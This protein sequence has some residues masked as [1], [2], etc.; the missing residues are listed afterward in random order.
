MAT[1]SL[2][3]A[4]VS[5]LRSLKDTYK[6]RTLRTVHAVHSVICTVDTVYSVH[7]V[8]VVLVSAVE[9]AVYVKML[10][11]HYSSHPHYGLIITVALL[12]W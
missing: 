3:I 12:L 11:Q 7:C 4:R 6:G 9:G 5:I 2:P 10:K 8:I 1:C